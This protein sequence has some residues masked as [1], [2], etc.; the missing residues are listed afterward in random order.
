MC[1]CDAAQVTIVHLL[2]HCPD[3]HRTPAPTLTTP[4]YIKTCRLTGRS[5]PGEQAARKAHGLGAYGGG[6]EG[7]WGLR[8]ARRLS[9]KKKSSVHHVICYYNGYT[10]HVARGLEEFI[11]AGS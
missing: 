4:W 3:D 8:S 11:L 7:Y 10:L 2:Q 5:V 1:R 6:R 9:E